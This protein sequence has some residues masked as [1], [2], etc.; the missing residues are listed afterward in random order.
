M[1]QGVMVSDSNKRW[2]K[3]A[4]HFNPTVDVSNC[5]P[6]K[7]LANNVLVDLGDGEEEN[8]SVGGLNDEE[9]IDSQ[10][11]EVIKPTEKSNRVGNEEQGNSPAV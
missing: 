7:E 9:V 1:L 3:L 11:P 10:E 8:V 6:L 4:K 2:L 5:D